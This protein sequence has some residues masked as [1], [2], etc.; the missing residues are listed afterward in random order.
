[1]KYIPEHGVDLEIEA[2][3]LGVDLERY[4]FVWCARLKSTHILPFPEGQN[5][6]GTYALCGKDGQMR[7][8]GGN[9]LNW[10]VLYFFAEGSTYSICNKCLKAAK[11]Q[12]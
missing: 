5:G 8:A 7:E 9:H 6:L 10:S 12:Q 3:H 2:S 4:T 1:M 11:E